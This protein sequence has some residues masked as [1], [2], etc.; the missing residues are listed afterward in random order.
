MT[1]TEGGEPTSIKDYKMTVQ[2][3]NSLFKLILVKF[4]AKMYKYPD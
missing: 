4:V 2:D 1:K 3:K